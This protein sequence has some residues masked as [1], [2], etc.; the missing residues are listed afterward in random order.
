MAFGTKWTASL[1]RYSHVAH[2]IVVAVLVAICGLGASALLAY[3]AGDGDH[4]HNGPVRDDQEPE[5]PKNPGQAEAAD[6]VQLASGNYVTTHRD[7]TVRGGGSAI[8]ILRSYNSQDNKHDGPL[9]PG[10][11]LAYFWSLTEVEHADGRREVIIRDGSGVQHVFVQ[12]D[13]GDYTPPHGHRATLAKQGVGAFELVQPDGIT[14]DFADGRLTKIASSAGGQFDL[15]YQLDGKLTRVTIAPGRW[16][17]FS[18]GS[19]NKVAVVTDPAGRTV[20]YG[21]DA[22]NRLTSVTDPLGQTIH[23]RYEGQDRLNTFTDA[24]GTVQVDNDYDEQGRVSSQFAYGGTFR[25]SYYDDYTAVRDRNGRTDYHYFNN[26]GNLTRHRNALGDYTDYSYDDDS[27]L[28]SV[29]DANGHTTSFAYDAEGRRISRTDALGNVISYSYVGAPYDRIASVTDPLGRIT[30]FEYDDRWR[31]SRTIDAAGQSA[32]FEYNGFGSITRTVDEAG[33][34]DT[35]TYNAAG[36]LLSHTDPLGNTTSYAYDDV[37][38]LTSITDPLGNTIGLSYDALDRLVSVTDGLGRTTGFA[39][40]PANNLGSTTNAAGETTSYGW[41]DHGQLLSV[42]DPLGNATTYT[43]DGNENLTS[44]TDPNG[45]TTGF[46]YDGLNRHYRTRRADGRYLNFEYDDVGNL[47]AEEDAYNNETGYAYTE[48]NRLAQIDFVDG[49]SETFTYDAIGNLITST[50]R[51]GRTTT[52]S[53]DVLDRLVEIEQPND[54]ATTYAYNATGALLS[55]TNAAGTVLF[56]RDALDRPE[57]VTDVFGNLTSYS[58]DTAGRLATLTAPG[59][60]VSTYQFDAAD[61]LGGAA[62]PSGTVSFTYD[63]AG[64]LTAKTLPNGIDTATLLDATGRPTQIRHTDGAGTDLAGLDY[65]YDA[66]SRIQSQTALDGT[67]DEYAY[68]NLYRLTQEIVRAADDSIQTQTDYEYDHNGNRISRTRGGS[69]LTYNYDA[70]NRLLSTDEQTFT[71]D[72]NANLETITGPSGTTTYGYDDRNQL[73]SVTAPDG[74][75]EVISYDALG[76]QIARVTEGTTVR[77]VY[78]AGRA[79]LAETDAAN[80]PIRTYERALG[81]IGYGSPV[82]SKYHLFDAFGTTLSLSDDTAALAE[83]YE[84]D[85]FGI[86]TAPTGSVDNPFGYRGDWGYYGDRPDLLKVGARDYIPELGRFLQVDPAL[87]GNNWYVYADADPVN[88]VDP[89]GKAA[90]RLTGSGAGVAGGRTR[91]GAID[92]G[93]LAFR[94]KLNTS[95]SQ[96]DYGGPASL[97]G[98]SNLVIALDPAASSFNKALGD[99]LGHL[100]GVL[101]VISFLQDPSAETAIPVLNLNAGIAGTLAKNPHI[102]VGSVAFGVG[103]GLLGQVIGLD[104]LVG[105]SLAIPYAGFSDWATGTDLLPHVMEQT[106]EILSRKGDAVADALVPDIVEDISRETSNAIDYFNDPSNWPNYP[107]NSSGFWR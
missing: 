2:W 102:V 43:Y 5:N 105:A 13:N 72:V 20:S 47:V 103:Y 56:E 15:D 38:R 89:N 14:Y 75:A 49:T 32:A 28:L 100:G 12:E 92:V 80:T 31:L 90:E 24:R 71:Y 50:D 74:S 64:R 65:V 30:R 25:F 57:R 48:R 82:G 35:F 3:D 16:V 36:D 46:Y 69:T 99:L 85:A 8:Q 37:G 73:V 95:G 59:N 26:H 23:Y 93:N 42:T 60:R 4:G 21:Y 53:Y 29:T 39:Y 55:A 11:S 84:M 98:V 104:E 88:K 81:L 7:L 62:L 33:R 106:R 79:L 18:Y 22:R 9:G 10:W 76:R 6:P 27:N 19:N 87:Y 78:G 83:S 77:L 96:R 101:D 41:S 97:L 61:Q 34:V 58:Y 63:L 54:G 51:A 68:D 70:A 67:R 40:D 45:L 44:A 52:Y 86:Q 107:A 17:D 1:R 91:Q 66:S 94:G